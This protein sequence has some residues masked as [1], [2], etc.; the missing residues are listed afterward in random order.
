MIMIGKRIF[1]QVEYVAI[2]LI[3]FL[4]LYGFSLPVVGNSSYLGAFLL[5][6]VFL[7][8]GVINEY[9]HI[10]RNRFVVLLICGY[11]FMSFFSVL[12]SVFNGTYDYSI[13]TTLVNNLISVLVTCICIAYFSIVSE[14][15]N[16]SVF[17]FLSTIFL[18]QCIIIFIML[19]FPD[20]RELIQGLIRDEAQL[21]R[22]SSYNGVRGLGLTGFVA[23]GFS[24][25]MG[26][27]FPIFC[28]W[29]KFYSRLSDSLKIASVILGVIACLSAGRTSILGVFL[30]FFI[31][32]YNEI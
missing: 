1:S 21:E 32:I 23:F 17:Y 28:Y 29:L 9:L 6:F 7:K 18:S 25:T 13:N 24:I 14:D 20:F 16:K 4:F 3:Y 30:G 12:T 2:T 19:L 8:K 26:L 15:I 10:I 22:M 31:L 27:L 11:F 5:F